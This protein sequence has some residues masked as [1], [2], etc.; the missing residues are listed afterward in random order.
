MVIRVIRVKWATILTW[1]TSWT[2]W[3]GWP[4]W[5]EMSVGLLY[6]NKFF[7]FPKWLFIIL[8][9]PNVGNAPVPLI[10]APTLKSSKSGNFSSGVGNRGQWTLDIPPPHQPRSFFILNTISLS[11]SS[12]RIV[13]NYSSLTDQRLFLLIAIVNT[14]NSRRGIYV[15][16]FCKVT[17]L[18][19][20]Q[21]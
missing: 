18:Y 21:E 2:G 11:A 1:V 6:P 17:C 13:G 8:A 9:L 16:W 19:R 12:V 5:N 4:G 10:N 15:L 3:L 20:F 7:N 14:S